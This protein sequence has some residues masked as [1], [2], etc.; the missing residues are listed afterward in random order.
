MNYFNKA[1]KIVFL[2]NEFPQ[3][4]FFFRNLWFFNEIK[5]FCVIFFFNKNYVFNKQ[6]FCMSFGH[7]HKI[8]VPFLFITS[9]YNTYNTSILYSSRINNVQLIK[10]YTILKWECN[11]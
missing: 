4:I 6:E 3:E 11:E 10:Y 1:K 5:Y 2:G 8:S 7:Y 9:T